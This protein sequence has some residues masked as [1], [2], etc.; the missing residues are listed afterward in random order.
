MFEGTRVICLFLC[1]LVI[2]LL[3]WMHVCVSMLVRPAMSDLLCILVKPRD[4]H[5][6]SACVRDVFWQTGCYHCDSFS[7]TS[8]VISHL[9]YKRE[10]VYLCFS[11]FLSAFICWSCLGEVL[12]VLTVHWYLITVTGILDFLC[13]FKA[14]HNICALRSVGYKDKP[15]RC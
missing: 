10:S 4:C 13:E 15:V 7:H 2:L 3:S 12:F 6:S 8:H 1:H 9:V 11:C 14:G 5:W